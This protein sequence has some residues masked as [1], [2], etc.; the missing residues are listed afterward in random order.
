MTFLVL[1]LMINF[2]VWLWGLILWGWVRWFK[3]ERKSRVHR[4]LSV[5]GFSLVTISA[6]L[7]VP[8]IIHLRTAGLF[9]LFDPF[10][11]RLSVGGAVL[12]ACGIV[13]TI[14]GLRQPDPLR[15]Q[16]LISGFVTLVYWL[17]V[18]S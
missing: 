14:T 4:K 11:L 6:F 12:S 5:L 8:S 9:A 18:L 13:L 15:W 2:V 1:G 10:L 3:S 17:F 16:A 7:V